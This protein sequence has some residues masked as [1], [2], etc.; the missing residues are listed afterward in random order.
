MWCD[1][2]DKNN[3]NTDD[4]RAIAKFKQQKKT[5]FEA[6]AGKHG[7]SFAQGRVI[8]TMQLSGSLKQQPHKITNLDTQFNSTLG[9]QH[10]PALE[11]LS[12]VNLGNNGY[13]ITEAFA[14]LEIA[15]ANQSSVSQSSGMFQ[16]ASR[17]SAGTT[18]I[19][20]SNGS[21]PLVKIVNAH[22]DDK[23]DPFYTIQLSDGRE[24]QTDNDHLLA[25]TETDELKRISQLLLD[26]DKSQQIKVIE[27]IQR[28]KA[29]TLTTTFSSHMKPSFS[30]PVLPPAPNIAP[31]EPPVSPPAL[32]HGVPGLFPNTF[33]MVAAG[34]AVPYS[35]DIACD[36]NQPAL[37]KE[38]I[39]VF[40]LQQHQSSGHVIMDG[41]MSSNTHQSMT[42]Q[43]DMLHSKAGQAAEQAPAS[44]KGNPFDVY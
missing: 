24:K 41:K 5:C 39:R 19:Y 36:I 40:P 38:A 12:T 3:H 20:I 33:G 31:P 44:P 37:S 7:L 13:R 22:F 10:Y 42:Y 30:E 17:F 1:Y 27:F 28:L 21:K 29:S 23:L 16:G 2:C 11:S 4:C 26:L 18:A 25:Y 43:D 35:I 15:P 6:K 8:Q 14:S 9:Q 34:S 32:N